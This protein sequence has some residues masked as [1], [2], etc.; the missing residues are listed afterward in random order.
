MTP[1]RLRILTPEGVAFDG[2]AEMITVRTT[3]GDK[4]IL[5]RHEPY[6]AA[7]GIG[8]AKVRIDGETRIAAVSS[9]SIEVSK[10]VTTLLAQ[11]FEW[12]DEIDLQRAEKA[13]QMAEENIE[14]YKNDK[15]RLD[16]AEYKLKRAIN[17]IN[18][19]SLKK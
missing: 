4:G 5:A 13:Q 7:L 3:V 9:G 1:F 18:V 17:R 10:D 16:I 6:V 12:A 19:A 15:R 2:E 11:S 14:R 8:Q